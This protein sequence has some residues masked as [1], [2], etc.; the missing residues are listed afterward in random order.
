MDNSLDHFSVVQFPCQKGGGEKLAQSSSFE[1][2]LTGRIKKERREFVN[3]A[4]TK[5]EGERRWVRT[6]SSAA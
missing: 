1:K 2:N 4:P 6:M 5:T 3:R